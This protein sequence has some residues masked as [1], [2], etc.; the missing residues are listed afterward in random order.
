MDDI[1]IQLLREIDALKRRVE[2][3]EAVEVEAY[4]RPSG[5]N[6]SNPPT[7]AQL[8]TAFGQP[9]DLRWGFMGLVDDN[10]ADATVWL[11]ATNGTS[12]WYEQLTKAL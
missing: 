5:N 7:D 9:A 11:V 2:R 1:V 8:D 6:V 3:L 10:D 4:A 12:W